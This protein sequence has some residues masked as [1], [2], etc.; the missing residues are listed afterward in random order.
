MLFHKILK[1]ANVNMPGFLPEIFFGGGRQNLFLHPF[2]YCSDPKF[3]GGRKSVSG[4]DKTLEGGPCGGKPD[5][6]QRYLSNET[7]HKCNK[8]ETEKLPTKVTTVMLQISTH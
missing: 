6:M 4:L 1:F 3:Y 7:K 5:M 2:F 8:E